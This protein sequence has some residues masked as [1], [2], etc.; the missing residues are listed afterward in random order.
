MLFR[1]S[2]RLDVGLWLR[3]LLPRPAADA[4]RGRGRVLRRADPGGRL[5]PELRAD[6]CRTDFGGFAR[7]A[8]V[9]QLAVIAA[10]ALLMTIMLTSSPRQTLLLKW[11]PWLAIPAAALLA[12]VLHPAVN[13]LQAVVQQL[14]PDQRQ[15]AG[16][17]WRSCRSCSAR[18]TS[19]RCCWSSPWCRPSARNWPSAA[20]FS[21]ASGTW[22]TSGGRSSISA[23]FFG[24]THGILQQSLIACLVGVVIGY[25]AVQSGSIL[26]GMVFHVVH[27]ALAVANM[28]VTSETWDLFPA[29]RLVAEPGERGGCTFGWPAVIGGA[30]VGAALLIWF[31]VLP[32]SKSPEE[33]L[34]EAIEQSEK[35]E[36]AAGAVEVG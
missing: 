6:A 32:G 31:A 28:H 34:E 15:R 8:L 22:A 36:V 18:P 24:L 12:V 27:N 10:P 33:A 21:P 30:L 25:L 19:G 35:S 9:T 7:M 13:V 4:D 11:P 1:E 16:R 20:S 2:E 23:V 29:L 5:L 3:H 17:R 14:Y 26:P